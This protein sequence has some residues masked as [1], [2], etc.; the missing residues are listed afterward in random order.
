MTFLAAPR[1]DQMDALCVLN[2]PANGQSFADD[3]EQFLLP[4]LSPGDIVIMDNLSRHKRPAHCLF[5]APAVD[6]P[7]H[8]AP[9]PPV[10]PARRIDAARACVFWQGG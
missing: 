3:V 9:C 10:P 2:Q 1:C 8:V 6:E 4:T 7:R 5:V